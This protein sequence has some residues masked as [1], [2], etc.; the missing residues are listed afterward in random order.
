FTSVVITVSSTMAPMLL[1]CGFG[2]S[3][4][5]VRPTPAA[6]KQVQTAALISIFRKV[7]LV[8]IACSPQE[9]DGSYLRLRLRVRVPQL[10]RDHPHVTTNSGQGWSC[11]AGA[12]PGAAHARCGS[13]PDDSRPND[14]PS[15]LQIASRSNADRA[16]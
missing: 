10:T 3:A 6:V 5:D 7:V 13:P 1:L 15:A 9:I 14:L 4:A 12:A 11:D 2:S 16:N 8:S